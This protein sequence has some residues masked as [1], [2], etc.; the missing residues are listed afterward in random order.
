MKLKKG[1]T[2]KIMSGKDRGKTG[3]IMNVFPKEGRIIVEG[4]HILKKRSRPK[5]QGAK[6]ETVLVARAFDASNASLLCKNCKNPT[7]VGTRVEGSAKVRYCKK[8]D[9]TL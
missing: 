9:A 5:T 7:R 4:V 1:D 3:T 8:C 2:V 6:G